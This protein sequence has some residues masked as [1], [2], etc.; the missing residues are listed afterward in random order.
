MGFEFTHLENPIDPAASQARNLCVTGFATKTPDK[1][2]YESIQ[3]T[4]SCGRDTPKTPYMG[5]TL[6]PDPCFQ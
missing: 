2:A 4:S 1:T 6:A 5:I 3:T